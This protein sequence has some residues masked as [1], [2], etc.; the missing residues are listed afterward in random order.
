VI[1]GTD[2]CQTWRLYAGTD[3]DFGIL[4]GFA[5]LWLAQYPAANQGG[6]DGAACDFFFR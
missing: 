4:P 2:D 5:R 3:Q 6:N 1:Y